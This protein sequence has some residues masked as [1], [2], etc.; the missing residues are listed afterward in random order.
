MEI[1]KENKKGITLIA[2]VVTIV[3]LLILAGISIGAITG[4]NG[5]I[6]QAQNAKDDTQKAQWEEQIDVAIIDAE[7]KNRNPNMDDVIEE[8]KNKHVIDDASQVN[9]ETGTITTNEPVYDIEGKLDDYLKG[10]T[11][12]VIA[13]AEDKR[14]YYGAIVKNYTCENSAGVNAWK[15]FYADENNIYIIADDYI[16]YEYI[17][18]SPSGKDL[19]KGNTNY[20]AYFS[21]ILSDY[22]G[23]MNITDEKLKALNNDY[24]NLKGYSSTNNNMKAVA[25]MLDIDIWSTFAGSKAEYAIGGPTIEMLMNSYS[26]KYEVN[27]RAQASNDKGYEISNDDYWT[28]SIPKMLDTNDSLY[29]INSIDKAEAMWLSSPSPGNNNGN[30]VMLV[31][32]SGYVGWIAYTGEKYGFRPLVCL[33]SDVELEKNDDGTYSI[34]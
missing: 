19:N 34:K 20:K 9:E 32:N 25:Y 28:T 18:K 16:P 27:Y 26:Q 31:L 5:I 11:A 29:V 2:L 23:S 21:N 24:F 7:S 15:I 33:N 22:S 6:N 12:D 10:I 17:P 3:V 8:L 14:E 4:N 13:N 1:L 30:S